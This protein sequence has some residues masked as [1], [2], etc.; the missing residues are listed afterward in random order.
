[1]NALRINMRFPGERV[2]AVTLSYDDQT[3]QDIRLVEIFDKNGMKATFNISTGLYSPEGKTF[4]AGEACRRMTRARAVELYKNSPHEVA[5]H[6]YSHT[7]LTQLPPVGV[8]REVLEDRVG[9]EADFERHVRGMA[10]PFGD[11]SYSDEVAG[12]LRASGIVY[13]RMTS[14]VKDFR[15]PADW[16]RWH[17]TCKHTNEQLMAHAERFINNSTNKEPMLFYVWGHSYEFEED[18]NWNVIEEFCEYM[19]GRD[20][21]WYATNIEIYDYV[22]AYKRL[23][24]SADMR[25]VYNPSAIPV[26]F[27]RH[28]FKD[29]G[30]QKI[31]YTVDAGKTLCFE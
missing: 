6:G 17:P 5:V 8:T 21:V 11:N 28:T 15:L 1:M 13:S 2:K 12:A 10:Y 25:R 24:W 4:E 9:L 20:D 29:G 19:G 14:S 26:S 30:E 23:V 7:F 22:E 18:D 16:L 3:E 31:T 27:Q